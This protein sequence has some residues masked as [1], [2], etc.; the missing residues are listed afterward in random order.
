MSE[1]NNS[2]INLSTKAVIQKNVFLLLYI[3]WSN[4]G[5]DEIF[6]THPH[7]PRGPPS[8]LYKEYRII[9]GFSVAGALRWPPTSPSAEVKER[10]KLYLYSTLSVFVA[11][12]RV[13]FTFLITTYHISSR[14]YKSG[15]HATTTEISE[16]FGRWHEDFH[17]GEN[18]LLWIVCSQEETAWFTSASAAN[19]SPPRWFLRVLK[20]FELIGAR[21]VL[22]YCEWLYCDT[23][24]LQCSTLAVWRH[25]R[26]ACAHLHE[27]I[28]DWGYYFTSDELMS[29]FWNLIL[30]ECSVLHNYGGSCRL[31]LPAPLYVWCTQSLGRWTHPL[32]VCTTRIKVLGFLP[33]LLIPQVHY[34]VHNS[35]QLFC[36]LR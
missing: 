33:V 15:L 6:C 3:R 36:I 30:F 11:C 9:S 32:F 31:V 25:E 19:R 12:S 23:T 26:Y 14:R 28:C 27:E 13:T 1:N 4:P 8:V 7:K 20:G 10:V 34:R 21:S 24:R 29:C 5:G 35:W 17:R 16:F 2:C 22:P 18:K